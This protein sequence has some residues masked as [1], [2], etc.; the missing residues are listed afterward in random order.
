M[1]EPL[2]L[3]A[4]LRDYGISLK[5]GLGQ[6]FLID[7]NVLQRIV[8]VAAIDKQT[9]VFEIGAGAGNLTRYLAAS[10]RHVTT[11]E[12]DAQIIPILKKVTGQFDNV[13]IIQGDILDLIISDIM[14]SSGYVVVANIPYYITSALIRFLLE[15][16]KKPKS[17]VLTIQ[18]EVAKRVC[19][20]AGALSLLALSVQLYGAPRIAF[21]IPAEAFYPTPKVDSAVL[22]IDLFDQPKIPIEKIDVFFRLSKTE[23]GQK[24]K[25]LR[26]TLGAASDLDKDRAGVLL[27][28]A[29]IDPARRAQTLTLDEWKRLIDEYLNF[30]EGN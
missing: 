11:V 19:A 25:M 27:K 26:N 13:R 21:R 15:S 10:A 4:M 6:N 22:V 3:P 14:E 5:K 16:T 29:D 30:K 23:F 20:K 24:R 2:R 8:D 1:F 17:I 18:H 12:I 28:G 7:E 9:E